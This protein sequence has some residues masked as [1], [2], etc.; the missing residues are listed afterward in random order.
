MDNF[1]SIVRT[2]H[3]VLITI[4]LAILAFAL[5]PRDA[6]QYSAAQLEARFLAEQGTS[7]YD[8][9]DRFDRKQTEDVHYVRDQ[10]KQ[11]GIAVA[12]QFEYWSPLLELRPKR[13]TP[14]LSD[15][16]DLS[17]DLM[18][19][20]ALVPAPEDVQAAVKSMKSEAAQCMGPDF[21]FVPCAPL[22]PGWTITY[23]RFGEYPPRLPYKDIHVPRDFNSIK[24]E[25]YLR[26]DFAGNDTGRTY[27]FKV[28][29]PLTRTVGDLTTTY[30]E[31]FR[32]LVEQAPR[33]REARGYASIIGRL[34][35]PVRDAW[36]QARLAQ[37]NVKLN[38]SSSEAFDQAGL[39]LQEQM[40]IYRTRLARTQDIFE[41]YGAVCHPGEH[42]L[43]LEH[44]DAVWW[45][46]R[47][48][49]ADEVV[50]Y[51]QKK[52]A[53]SRINIDIGGIQIEERSVRSILPIA[54][55]LVSL[56][57]LSNLTIL[58]QRNSQVRHAAT[59]EDEDIEF[60]WMGLYSDRLSLTLTWITVFALPVF[61]PLLLLQVSQ[62]FD[63]V[64]A[65]GVIFSVCTSAIALRSL[66][67]VRT[68]RN[69]RIR[70]LN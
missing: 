32:Q 62:R 42:I 11:N 13:E 7:F 4:T 68:I 40:R 25:W 50:L 44:L 24:R 26:L 54:C 63:A 15:I 67:I 69:A 34:W 23:A 29:V 20:Q 12:E 19:A 2:T 52:I 9:F 57:L 45:E 27:V 37:R 58:L 55:F 59:G 47:H 38:K 49:T 53:E 48:L 70:A 56:F 51:L 65:I 36:C 6:D 41:S 22:Q 60:P 30:Y 46:V 33:V 35:K 61:T 39:P 8:Q 43:G 31:V 66:K 5:S 16:A 14:V 28:D 10:L 3:F 1:V 17:T 21:K 18:Y 64:Y